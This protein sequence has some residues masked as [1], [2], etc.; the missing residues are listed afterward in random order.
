MKYI[1][2]PDNLRDCSYK[3]CLQKDSVAYYHEGDLYYCQKCFGLY[4]WNGRTIKQVGGEAYPMRDK[5][6]SL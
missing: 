3:D 5:Q 4:Q 6:K 1:T 2:L